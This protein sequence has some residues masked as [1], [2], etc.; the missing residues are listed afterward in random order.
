MNRGLPAAKFAN[1]R[2]RRPLRACVLGGWTVVVAMLSGCG[3]SLFDSD[4]PVPTSYVLA[5]VP[6]AAA[7]TQSFAAT[8]DLSIGRPDVAPGLDTQ[9]IAVLRGHQLDYFRGALWGGTTNEIVQALLVSSLQDQQLFRSVTFE[10]ARVA[11]HYVIDVEVRHFQ[12]EYDSDAAAPTANVS[13][14]ARLIRV[15]DRQLVATLPSSARIVASENRLGAVI[16]AFETA[17]QQVALDMARKTAAA[18]NA[19]AEG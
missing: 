12:A 16:D 6:P 1:D 13:L 9:R 15:K 19:D 2:A 4:I 10:Q 17:A 5:S 14:V 18:V 11:G 3:G 7:P 8:R